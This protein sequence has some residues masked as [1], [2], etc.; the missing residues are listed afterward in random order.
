MSFS[1]AIERLLVAALSLVAFTV[2]GLPELDAPEPR[3]QPSS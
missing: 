1:R 2:R 3:S